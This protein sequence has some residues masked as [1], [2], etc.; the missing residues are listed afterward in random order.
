[1]AVNFFPS[2]RVSKHLIKCWCGVYNNIDSIKKWWNGE[3]LCECG[4]IIK[5]APQEWKKN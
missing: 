4:Q 2:V 1:M 3:P 5:N